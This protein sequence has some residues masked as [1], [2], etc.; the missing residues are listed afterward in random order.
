MTSGKKNTAE[1]IVTAR[2]HKRSIP[3]IVPF[4]ITGESLATADP[5]FIE[6]EDEKG[7]VGLGEASSFPVLTGDSPPRAAA[8]AKDL[9]ESLTDLSVDGALQRLDAE[10]GDWWRLSSTAWVGVES[11]LLD[12]KA[13]QQGISLGALFGSPRKNDFVTDITLP[14]LSAKDVAHFWAEVQAMSFPVVKIK[15]T[16]N[17]GEDCDRVRALVAVTP[18]SVQISFDGNQGYSKDGA[19]KLLRE[20]APL[21]TPVCFEQPVPMDDLKSA[22]DLSRSSPVPICLDESVKTTADVVQIAANKIAAGFNL[23][24]MKSGVRET[25]NMMTAGRQYGL[26]MMI[27][28][29]LESEI[30]MGVSLQ[31]L[32]SGPDVEW[33]DL[34]TPFFF[35]ERPTPHSPWHAGRS[36]LRL[37][38]GMG[39]GLHLN[40]SSA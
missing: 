28:G 17:L 40:S 34:D 37:P 4:K 1:R 32:G 36:E 23:K 8:V 20:L 11:A 38:S 21:V 24:I 6:L 16:G 39:H 18:K 2:V 33:I 31:L 9:C 30:A 35:R 13:R 27:G 10:R 19:L 7:R 29:M 3:I 26:R 25:W 22:A 12:L 15:V 14:A 5:V